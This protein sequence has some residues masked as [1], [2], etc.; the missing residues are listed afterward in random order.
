MDPR[1][2]VIDQAR[3]QM[4]VIM[5]IVGALLIL[6]GVVWFFQ[7]VNLLPGSFMT[8]QLEWAFFGF[9]AAMMGTGILAL[10]NRRG[11]AEPRQQAGPNGESE[12][13]S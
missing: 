10:A 2:E 3:F 7:G 12:T 4:K 6:T 1:L 8:G 9:V 5:T 13:E 11:K